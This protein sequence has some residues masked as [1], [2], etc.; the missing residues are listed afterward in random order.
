MTNLLTRIAAFILP[1]ATAAG[2]LLNLAGPAEAGRL[3]RAYRFP[4]QGEFLRAVPPDTMDFAQVQNPDFGDD[5]G[6][7]GSMDQRVSI[8]PR[9]AARIARQA[10]P[11]AKVLNVK[12]LP[13]GVY[14]VT[15][16]GDGKLTRVM[17]DG[18]S[19]DIL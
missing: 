16:R 17:V 19:G 10:V 14:A 6:M 13:S 3:K 12:L 18:R 7:G 4:D 9:E 15:L 5:E 2:L 11:G 8:R 1:L